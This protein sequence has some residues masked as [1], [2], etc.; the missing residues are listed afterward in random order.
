MQCRLPVSA[1]YR[2][3]PVSWFMTV[4]GRPAAAA[5]AE[6]AQL[7]GGR[8]SLVGDSRA[9]GSPSS[10]RP[11]IPILSPRLQQPVHPSTST[12]ASP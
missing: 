7:L 3:W 1:R 12:P 11:R 8:V 6:S 10:M 5:I 9:A 4:S 2:N